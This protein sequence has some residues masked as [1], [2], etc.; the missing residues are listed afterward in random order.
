MIFKEVDEDENPEDEGS[1]ANNG[2]VWGGKYL[3]KGQ[4][5]LLNLAMILRLKNI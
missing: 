1:Y 5:E 2:P 4:S 3:A